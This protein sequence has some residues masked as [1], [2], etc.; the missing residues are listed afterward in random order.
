VDVWKRQRS[1]LGRGLFYKATIGENMS[2]TNRGS[3]GFVPKQ[4][5]KQKDGW[6]D[7]EARSERQSCKQ[8]C[9]KFS[10]L[11][12]EDTFEDL[13]PLLKYEPISEEDESD[14]LI[15]VHTDET[16]DS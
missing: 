15:E 10:S 4:G 8:M 12:E 16:L 5:E 14:P 6:H 3:K 1:L 2:R 11:T 13:E 7:R 9:R